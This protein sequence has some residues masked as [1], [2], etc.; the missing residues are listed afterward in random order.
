M[1]PGDA[2]WLTTERLAF[3]RWTA[4]DLDLARDLW[5]D[6]RVTRYFHAGGALSEDAVRQRLARELALDGEHGIQYWP[7]FLRDSAE[8]AG[9]CGLRPRDVAAGVLELGFHVVPRHWGRGLATE[10]ARGIIAHAF[11]RLGVAALHAGHHPENAASRRVLEKLGFR[12]TH[13]ELYEPTGIEHPSYLLTAAEHARGT[14]GRR[15][16]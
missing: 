5:G 9:C 15:E 11:G 6:A 3:R 7:F 14:V 13:D 10:A 16:H 1:S 4:G 8:H 12:Y 2:Y